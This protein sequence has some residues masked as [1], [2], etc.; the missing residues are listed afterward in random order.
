M[1]SLAEEYLKAG[2]FPEAVREDALHVAAAVL[3]RQNILLSWN[4]KHLVN[5]RRKAAV[6]AINLGRGLPSVEIITPPEL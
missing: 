4:Y 5:R 1:E 2:V 3:T 6:T